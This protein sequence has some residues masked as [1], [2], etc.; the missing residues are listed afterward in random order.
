MSDPKSRVIERLRD[1]LKLA[2]IA[3]SKERELSERYWMERGRAEFQR[4][5]AR[6]LLKQIKNLVEDF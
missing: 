1:E 5:K 6:D 2:R 4:D 3:L